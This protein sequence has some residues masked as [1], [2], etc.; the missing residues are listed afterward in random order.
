MSMF[1]VTP[2]VSVAQFLSQLTSHNQ[3]IGE[4]QQQATSGL[5]IH[6]AS[7]DPAGLRSVLRAEEAITRL[8]TRNTSINVARQRLEQA[9][10]AVREAHS[11]F[12]KAGTLATEA[13]QAIDAT[14]QSV[15]ASEIDSLL[16]QI[17][18]LVNS[19]VSD[20]YVFAGI[21]AS[22]V[23]FTRSPNAET[24]I[25]HGS[26]VPRTLAV[27]EGPPLVL[28]PSG[29]EVFQPR[30][31]ATTVYV[32]NTGATAG[33]ATDN[34][35][36]QGTLLVRH[37][38]TTFAAGS[39]VAAG[40]TSAT[41]DTLIGPAGAYVLTIEDASGIGSFGTVSLNG[42]PPVEFTS[43]DT[44]L[45][46]TGPDG[47]LIHLDTTNITPSFAGAVDITATGTLSTDG[48]VTETPIDFT[49][50]QSLSDS[51]SG[52]ITH[53]NTSAIRR[54]G[55]EHLEYAGTS[56]AFE[57]LRELRDDIRNLRG[58]PENERQAALGRR[59]TEV[60]RI[61]DHLLDVVGQQSVTLAHL[62]DLQAHGE[63]TLLEL[64]KQV[65][66][67]ASADITQVALQLQQSQSQLQYTL[68]TASRLFEVSLLDFLR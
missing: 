34:A 44:H 43:A 56:D 63:D 4:L 64:R 1:R 16:I 47:T 35:R 61:Q 27:H 29:S 3:R 52:A 39:G 30:T 13:V 49:S 7:D 12:V 48:G 18:A 42:G 54:A 60:H 20:E 38:V 25:Y 15:I 17:E 21:N 50:N 67:T 22:E 14:E 23:P 5:R 58:L 19:R 31:R 8:E 2:N 41:D 62:D 33:T 46:V 45:Q 6:R 26:D 57:T 36:G 10:I 9:H 55:D 24:T 51:R 66:E 68:A 65:S 59:L 53:V 37:G 28:L 32:G 40:T 11:L